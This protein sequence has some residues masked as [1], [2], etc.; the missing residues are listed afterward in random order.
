M[1][2]AEVVQKFMDD[3][4]ARHLSWESLRRY[5]RLLEQRL[6]IWCNAQGYKLLKQIGVP[7][8]R[9]FRASWS[10]GPTYATKNLEVYRSFFRF[11]VEAD[12][13]AKNPAVAVKAPKVTMRPTLPF[14]ADEMRRILDACDRYPGNSERMKAFVLV[15]RYGGSRI[16]DTICLRRDSLTGN[17]MFLRQAKTGEPVYVPV[18]KFVVAALARVES[19]GEGF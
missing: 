14:T 13:L 15:M 3:A 6:L 16:S 18:P 12:W 7:E 9:E 19:E 2:I 1:A 4:R 11:C 5:S 10:D 8:M 17:K